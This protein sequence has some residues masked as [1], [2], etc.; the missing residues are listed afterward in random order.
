M[1]NGTEVRQLL[2][3]VTDIFN[4]DN[5]RSGTVETTLRSDLQ[6]K[7]RELLA[8]REGSVVMLDPR[9]GACSPCTRTRPTTP[10]TSPSTTPRPPANS[11]I[12]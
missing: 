11:S 9:T 12:T 1:L 3:R 2:G 5:D 7:A 6:A 4:T 8:G 10:T